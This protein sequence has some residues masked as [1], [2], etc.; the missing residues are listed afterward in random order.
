MVSKQTIK[1]QENYETEPRFDSSNS[2]P[3]WWPGDSDATAS[4]TRTITT[5]TFPAY[6]G[7]T[8]VTAS[9]PSGG[10]PEQYYTERSPPVNASFRV[11][12]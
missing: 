7:N 6:T 8:Y 12:S 4:S 10:F 1:V 2:E 3:T 9:Q 11:L 5:S